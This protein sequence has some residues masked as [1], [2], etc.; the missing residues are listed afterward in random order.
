MYRVMNM[1]RTA[2]AVGDSGIYHVMLR[3]INRQRIFEDDE[4]REKFLEI[5]K[6]SKEKDGFDLL[7]WCLM[8]NH[9]HL[10]IKENEVKLG[11][12]FRRIGASYVYWYNGKYERTGHLFQDRF[13]SEPVEDDSYFLTVIQYIHRNPVKVGL[14]ERPEEYEYSSLK[15]YFEEDGLHDSGMVREMMNEKEFMEWNAQAVDEKCMDMAEQP[16]KRLTD[17][18]AWDLI[19][20]SSGCETTA[21][22]QRMERGK[23]DAVLRKALK[24]GVSIRQASRLTG[25]SIGVICRIAKD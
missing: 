4:D 21:E 16:Q 1:A 10:L 15:K 19:R 20:R 11:T 3:G 7:A 18:R 23:R 8:P 13:K 14:C 24:E 12:I 17:S 25:I 9:V 22:F 2:R 5:L 6:K